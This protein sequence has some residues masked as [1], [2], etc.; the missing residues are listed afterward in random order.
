MTKVKR[1]SYKGREK[2]I[3][4]REKDINQQRR[5]LQSRNK[6]IEKRGTEISDLGIVFKGR[7]KK[8]EMEK[9]EIKNQKKRR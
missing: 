1:T 8:V 3:T 2:N 6:E 4:K 7:V 9:I 5:R